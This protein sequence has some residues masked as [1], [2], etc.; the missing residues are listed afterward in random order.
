MGKKGKDGK[1]RTIEG[2]ISLTRDS[3]GAV[4]GFR[5][6][7]R[8]TTDRVKMGQELLRARK[9]EAIGILSGGIAHDYNNALTAILGNISLAKIEAGNSNV[10]LME[11]LDDAEKASMKIME[12]TKRL[13][14]FAK[15]GRPDKKKVKLIDFLKD[16]VDSVLQDYKG[17]YE[18]IA[19]NDLQDV[20]IDDIQI[21]HVIENIINNSIEAMPNGGHISVSARN[22]T[23]DREESHHEITL[24]QGNYIV[25]TISDNG[26][27]IPDDVVD[28]IFDPYFTTKDFASGM[29]LAISYAI[30]KRHRGYLDVKSGRDQGATFNVYLPLF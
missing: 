5:G 24:Q 25:I 22:M 18:F 11:T 23:V 19:Q 3:A 13:S 26:P 10:P 16:T 9:L 29:G 1:K 4:N 7:V 8:D 21:S 28:N 20:E 6:I 15:G 2:S 12:L 27:G 17:T 30:I 14:I